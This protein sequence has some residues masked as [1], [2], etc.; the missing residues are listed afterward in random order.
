MKAICAPAV[1]LGGFIFLWQKTVAVISALRAEHVNRFVSPVI[2]A[3]GNLTQKTANK[4]RSR[5]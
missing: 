4:W 1:M 5:V 2:R 3:V